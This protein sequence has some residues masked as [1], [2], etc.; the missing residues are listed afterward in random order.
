[1]ICLIVDTGLLV[2]TPLGGLAP[3]AFGLW[4]ASFGGLLDV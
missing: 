2:L 3:L 4:F 1:M